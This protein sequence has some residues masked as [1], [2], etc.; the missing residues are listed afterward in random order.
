MHSRTQCTAEII[1]PWQMQKSSVPEIGKKRVFIPSCQ[2]VHM[3]NLNW[4]WWALISRRD[5]MPKACYEH[6]GALRGTPG[7]AFVAG[8][9]RS[10]SGCRQS[11]YSAT[12]AERNTARETLG[13]LETLAPATAML[14]LPLALPDTCRCERGT[15]HVKRSECSQLGR[16]QPRCCRCR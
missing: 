2:I 9:P 5:E 6:R 7:S 15:L 14:P 13:V 3:K 10:S 4:T 12:P 1:Q 16:P 11:L 8:R